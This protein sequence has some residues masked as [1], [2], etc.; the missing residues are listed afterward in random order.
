MCTSFLDVG[1]RLSPLN[2]GW[3]WLH[4][5]IRS[6]RRIL[7]QGFLTHIIRGHTVSMTQ[8]TTVGL[9][10]RRECLEC[11]NT[12]GFLT[13]LVLQTSSPHLDFPR[14][15]LRSLSKYTEIVTNIFY[16]PPI[17][18]LMSSNSNMVSSMCTTPKL[19]S[20]LTGRYI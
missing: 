1:P 8:E 13:A 3:R 11:I 15:E 2:R 4:R 12:R 5:W 9:R 16:S 20:L 7:P 10:Y 17:A 6:S 14:L 19:Q 18:Y